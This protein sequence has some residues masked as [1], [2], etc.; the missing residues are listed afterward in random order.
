MQNSV[1]LAKSEVVLRVIRKSVKYVV[2]LSLVD[3]V[4]LE[5]PSLFLGRH[6]LHYFTLVLLVEAGLLFLI[7]GTLDFTGSLAFR[8]LADH[9]SGARKAWNF[10]HYKKKQEG[11]AVLVLA[12]LILLALSFLLA[13]PLN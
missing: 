3:V 13:Y 2:L 4:G 7:G 8:R 5:I 9:A 11:I 6:L 1:G 10:G 12:G